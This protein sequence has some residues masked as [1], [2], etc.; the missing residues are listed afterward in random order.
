M[1]VL[2]HHGRYIYCSVQIKSVLVLEKLFL[3]FR[4]S[5]SGLEAE[6]NRKLKWMLKQL[7]L[8]KMNKYT[9]TLGETSL[10]VLFRYNDNFS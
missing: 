1:T 7:L 9:C 3:L 4:D 5:T 6:E 2:M 10:R 8:G